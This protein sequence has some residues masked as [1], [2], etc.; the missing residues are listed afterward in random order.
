MRGAWALEFPIRYLG[1]C[2]FPSEFV[3][4]RLAS[5]VCHVAAGAWNGVVE[6]KRG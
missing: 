5:R 2:I 1:V 6:K 4:F 3:F